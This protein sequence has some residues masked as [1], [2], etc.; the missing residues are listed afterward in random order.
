MAHYRVEGT[1]EAYK[2]IKAK[3]PKDAIRQ[4][5]EIFSELGDFYL[6]SEE[7]YKENEDAGIC[8]MI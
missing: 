1:V 2:Y 6:V 4:A 7:E 8:L 5:R 3:S